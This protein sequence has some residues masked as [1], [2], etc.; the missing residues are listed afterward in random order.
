MKF[1]YL[2]LLSKNAP[3]KVETAVIYPSN[4]RKLRKAQIVKML[5]ICIYLEKYAFQYVVRNRPECFYHF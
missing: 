3:S 1:H 2:T 4:K 5:K